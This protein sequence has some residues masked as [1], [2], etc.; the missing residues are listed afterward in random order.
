MF[1]YITYTKITMFIQIV[2]F[3]MI[4]IGGPGFGSFGRF[5]R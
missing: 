2:R 1:Y 5:F 4:L 3:K